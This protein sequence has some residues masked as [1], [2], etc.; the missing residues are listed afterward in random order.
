M[1][2]KDQKEFYKVCVDSMQMGILVHNKD[3]FIVLYNNT[4][5][6]VFNYKTSEIDNKQIEIL[7]QTDSLFKEFVKYPSLDKF[8]HSLELVGLK[9][10]GLEIPIGATFGKIE[11]NI[12][13]IHLEKLESLKSDEHKKI[14]EIV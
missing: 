12:L 8:K 2:L 1:L 3:K 7:F 13:R 6:S 10:N 5:A 14:I 11:Y 9:K 4:L